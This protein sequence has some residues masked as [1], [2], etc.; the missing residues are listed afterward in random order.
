MY[1]DLFGGGQNDFKSLG[2]S[3]NSNSTTIRVLFQ[4]LH[5]G[6]EDMAREIKIS[7]PLCGYRARFEELGEEKVYYRCT[8]C[9][10]LLTLPFE[11][12][13]EIDEQEEL[14]FD[15]SETN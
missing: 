6:G 7:C 5:L 12:E 9:K 1:L 14:H 2:F 4:I 13:T 11:K 3:F 8:N 10:E 15:F